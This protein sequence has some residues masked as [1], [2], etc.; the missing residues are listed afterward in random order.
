[1]YVKVMSECAILS[2]SSRKGKTMI[3]KFTI[4]NFKCYGKQGAT[5]DLARIT[6]V[7]GNNSVGKSSFLEALK[8]LDSAQRRRDLVVRSDAFK[9][10][11]IAAED[12]WRLECSDLEGSAHNWVLKCNSES[13][14]SLVDRDSGEQITGP[15]YNQCVPSVEHIQ[16][17][18]LKKKEVSGFE[19]LAASM[20][21]DNADVLTQE[22]VADINNMFKDLKVP[23]SCSIDGS[24][25]DLDFDMVG[26]SVDKVGTGIR[27]IYRYLK[28]MAKWK[29][30]LLLFEE[31]EAN[32]NESQLQVLAQ[33]L[34]RVALKR[35]ENDA[36][37]QL[38]VE[39]HSEHVM[40]EVM[41]MVA[42]N[43][44]RC[45]DVCIVYVVKDKERGACPIR[46]MINSKGTLDK[47]PAEGGFFAAR[48]RILFGRDVQYDR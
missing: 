41:K 6:F 44:L 42:G 5:F 38:V 27:G 36:N 14:W 29:S 26:L 25:T 40:L 35:G 15:L 32:V 33:L 31:P 37:A 22:E 11:Q 7:Y 19:A 20:E 48:K 45:E 30:G 4:R 1:M 9:N 17:G 13:K 23:Y 18:D 47:W 3:R 28:A 34:I 8:I 21:G 12:E 43:Q 39:C 46:C 2:M 24:L 10:G 16:A